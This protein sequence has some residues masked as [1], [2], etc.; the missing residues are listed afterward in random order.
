[1]SLRL[2]MNWNP[3][4]CLGLIEQARVDAVGEVDQWGL[5]VESER[6]GDQFGVEGVDEAG[7]ADHA[8]RAAALVEDVA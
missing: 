8:G 4:L 2:C 3:H 6:G 5:R 1:M 7:A